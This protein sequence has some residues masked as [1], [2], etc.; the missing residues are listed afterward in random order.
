MMKKELTPLKVMVMMAIAFGLILTISCS[1]DDDEPA[2]TET[3]AEILAANSEYS[4]LV[5]FINADAELK[6][7]AE[8]TANV[9]FFAP[10]N[11]SFARLKAILGV[12]DLASIAPTV[13]GSVLRFHIVEGTKLSSEL[14]GGSATTV[15]GENITV[16]NLGFIN[17]AGSDA[18]GSEII[19][20]DIK[21]TNGVVHKIETI[22]IPPTV[23]L[24]I[25]INL[26]TLA[27]PILL[28]SN[29]TDV[30]SIIAK[31]DSEVP[32]GE[33]ALSAVLADKTT[34]YTCFI[35]TND[36]LTA[37]LKE[38]KDATIASLTSS[39]T[40]ARG[41]I[42]NHIM[43]GEVNADDL[44]S[45]TVI[46]MLSGLSLTVLEVPVGETTPL[47]WVLAYDAQ[48]PETYLPIFAAD[49]YKAVVP[50]PN[51]PDGSLTLSSAINGT[52]H[53][54]APIAGQ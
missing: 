42:L 23:F 33:T 5:A 28:G 14:I 51:D 35:P 6:A 10:T 44:V 11:T 8:G 22:L 45:G 38:N 43:A 26:G 17:E 16:N 13:I 53:V 41:F 15:Q 40:V 31:A 46:D 48:N 32:S 24:Q 19:T 36:V 34:K 29:F 7:Y 54:S 3:I 47:G 52:L 2:A 18:D 49:V 27:Q 1:E 30:V 25:G 39:A 37:V 12:D 50:D 9:T 4:E 21:A 20:A